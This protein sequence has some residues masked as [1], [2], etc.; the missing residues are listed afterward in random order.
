MKKQLIIPVILI[1]V[2]IGSIAQNAEDAL[3]FSQSFYGSTARSLSM[4]NAFGA[5]GADFSSLSINPA[6][7]GVY[8]KS[9]FMLTPGFSYNNIS[10]TYMSHKLEDFTYDPGF[11]NIGFIGSFNTGKETGWIST[12]IGFGFNRTNSFDNIILI[13]SVNNQSSL[14]DDFVADANQNIWN[15]TGNELAANADLIYF[16]EDDQTWKSDFSGSDYGQLQ[17]HSLNTKGFSGEYLF[18]A[19][20]NYNNQLY[21]GGTIAVSAIR[22]SSKLSHS[23]S[24]I[25]ID[26]DFLNSFIYQNNLDIRGSG[27]N[28]KLGAIFKPVQWMRLGA[29]IHSPTFYSL[30]DKYSGYV[31]AKLTIANE[32]P[33]RAS[34][35]YDYELIT[36]PRLIGS[37]GFILGKTGLLSFDY[38]LVDYTKARLRN[39]GD[40]YTFDV[41]NEMTQAIYTI[42]HNLRAG[43]EVRFGNISLRGG[44]A[45]YGSPYKSSEANS[46]AN[47]SVLS[48]GIGINN[49][50]F[51]IDFGYSYY[52]S[53]QTYYLYHT[54]G[55]SAGLDNEKSQILTTLGFRF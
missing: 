19:G 44:Y 9:E 37:L 14:L 13:R 27:V 51:Y 47:I 26:I 46:D 23:E 31:D 55:T 33:Q 25:P 29:A 48:G 24:E 52:T 6:G 49:N 41:E 18:S 53:S 16:D 4:G 34:G 8:R 50:N 22:Y 2:S 15:F 1:F 36:P 20:A 42:T 40:G 17:R 28:F 5:L 10:S 54:P 3:R 45:F 35:E 39:G 38:E 21:I 32:S 43:A 7:I 11:S 12:N 30:N